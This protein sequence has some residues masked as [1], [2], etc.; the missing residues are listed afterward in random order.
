MNLRQVRKKIK[1]VKNVRKITKAMQLVS[2]VKMR[3]AQAKAIEGRPYKEQLEKMIRRISGSEQMK[4]S[5][6]LVKPD[7]SAKR[8]LV[9]FISANKGLCGSFLTS[10]DRYCI[11][12][13]D[14]D[15]TDFVTVG[16]KGALFLGITKGNVIA[17]F[18][19]PH[20]EIE[21]SAIFEYILEQFRTNKYAKVSI[22]YNKFI[23]TLRFD[24]VQE[25]LMPLSLEEFT[26]AAEPAK[27]EETVRTEDKGLESH[28]YLIE[29]FSR[30][31]VDALLQSYLEEKI[32]SAILDSEAAEHSARMIAM[33]NATENAGTVIYNLTLEGNKLRQESIT[34]ELLDMI[35]AKESVEGS[36]S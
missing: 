21:A 10:L 12:K 27:T 25:Q 11:K 36:A 20:P 17:D 33:K 28:D 14:Y 9:L 19:S 1:S 23:N 16:K 6:F 29:P 7:A 8:E 31:I 22:L 18:S 5:Q 24:T 30:E 2:S 3:K 35:T 13:I 34:S 26:Q 4:E 32:R 15:T